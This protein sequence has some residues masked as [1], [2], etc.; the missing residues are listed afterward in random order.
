M[1]LALVEH[2]VWEP[3]TLKTPYA[4]D[5][6]GVLRHVTMLHTSPMVPFIMVMNLMNH[7]LDNVMIIRFSK[8]LFVIKCLIRRFARLHKC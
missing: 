2:S 8:G 1:S 6:F 7:G 5:C 4:H 3:L